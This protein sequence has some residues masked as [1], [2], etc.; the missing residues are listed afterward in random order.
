MP[1]QRLSRTRDVYDEWP[2]AWTQQPVP[3]DQCGGVHSD[4]SVCEPVEPTEDTP[5]AI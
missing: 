3:C 5:W 4:G 2:P 1:E